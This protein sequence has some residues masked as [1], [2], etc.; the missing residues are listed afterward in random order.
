MNRAAETITGYSLEELGGLH[1]GSVVSPEYRELA[2]QQIMRKLAGEEVT[3]YELEIIRKDGTPVPLEVSTWLLRRDGKPV[4]IQGIARDITKRREAENA[5]Q[6]SERRF[7]VLFENSS[8]AIMLWSAH[9]RVVYAT[10]SVQRVLGYREPE[11]AG[12][13]AMELVHPDDA[14][15]ARRLWTD[16]LKAPGATSSGL[17]RVRHRDGSWRW[18]EGVA[19]NLLDERGVE[20]IVA[21]FRDVSERIRTQQELQESVRL[22]ESAYTDRR[23]LMARLVTAQ[24]EERERIAQDIHDD[25]IQGLTAALMR[26]ETLRNHIED[27][28]QVEACDQLIRDVSR[29][30]VSLRGLIFEVHPHALD[31]YGLEPALRQLME[32]ARGQAGLEFSFEGGIQNEPPSAARQVVFRIAQEALT[33][34]LKHA[35]ARTVHIDLEPLDAGCRVRIR[36]DGVGFNVNGNDPGPGHLGLAGMRA[37]AHSA[38]GWCRVESSVGEGTLVEYWVPDVR[39]HSLAEDDAAV[40]S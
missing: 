9:G 35:R 37:R 39:P 1:F 16:V 38:G 8:D 14:D 36:D 30:I 40:E 27:P 18:I 29:C 32:R 23:A 21:T 4:G 17:F 12:R 2:K 6:E 11:I 33:N 25:S 19:K 7:R 3:T 5:A 15:Q 24:E 34:V 13:V 20:A 22:L 10:P 26:L 28:A 31:E